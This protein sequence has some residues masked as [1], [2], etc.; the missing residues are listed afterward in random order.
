MNAFIN[1][2]LINS[3]VIKINI[4]RVTLDEIYCVHKLYG[5]TFPLTCLMVDKYQRTEKELLDQ[6]KCANYR[7]KYFCGGGKFTH[8]ICGSD[9]HFMPT[10][11]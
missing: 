9:K 1:I 4:T 3:H 6:L 2:L 8:L 7:T 5:D 11:I 10:I